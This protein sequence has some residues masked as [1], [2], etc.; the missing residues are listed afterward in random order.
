MDDSGFN[1]FSND[2]SFM[3]NFVKMQEEK[4][5]EEESKQ[6]PAPP[7]PLFPSLVKKKPLVM[8]MRGFKKTPT[9]L[10]SVKTVSALEG[11]SPDKERGDAPVDKGKDERETQQ[12]K[13]K[14]ENQLH[15]TVVVIALLCSVIMGM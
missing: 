1:T 14:G 3:E 8:K 11:N 12:D 9:L 2:G 15:P 13:K 4:K 6:A 10:K 5:K 7:K